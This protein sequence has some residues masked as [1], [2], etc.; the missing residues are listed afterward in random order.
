[1]QRA[2]ALL[3]PRAVE[4]AK[5]WTRESV[6][7][8]SKPRVRDH[9]S[10]AHGLPPLLE[11]PAQLLQRRRLQRRCELVPQRGLIARDR[12]GEMTR[13][14]EANRPGWQRRQQVGMA[15]QKR[16]EANRQPA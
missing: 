2:I 6:L 15:V 3:Q 8:A 7:G 9:G 5:P 13:N 12:A 14:Q 1:V 4:D 11:K 16:P 10:R